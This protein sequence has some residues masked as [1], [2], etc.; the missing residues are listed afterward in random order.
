MGAVAPR[1]RQ[2]AQAWRYSG[3]LCNAAPCA[4]GLSGSRPGGPRSPYLSALSGTE[5][6]CRATCIRY[7]R[8]YVVHVA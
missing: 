8:P 5:A 4:V 7:S 2:M 3:S 6:V 1:T